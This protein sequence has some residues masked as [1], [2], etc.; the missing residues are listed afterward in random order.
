MPGRDWAAARNGAREADRTTRVLVVDDELDI[1]RFMKLYLQTEGYTVELALDGD[2]ALGA[3]LKDPPD[4]VVLD[5]ML[6][7]RDGL[8]VC[9]VLREDPRTAAIAIILV[10]AR[11]ETEDRVTGL[12]A[13][14]D[15]YI[16]KPFHPAELSARVGAALRRGRHLRSLSPLTGLPGNFE[17]LAE[18]ERLID[19]GDRPFA[20]VHADLDGFKAFNDHYGFL[21]GDEAIRTTG[22]V[23]LAAV[24]SVGG[25]PRFVGHI[26]GDDFAMVVA[27]DRVEELCE[28]VQAD[29]G[30]RVADLYDPEDREAGG[31]KVPDRQGNPHWFELLT[32]SMG[33]A[34]STGRPLTS[35]A[36]ASAIAS[37]LKGVAKKLP[38]TSWQ[39]DR[40][41]E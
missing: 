15:D 32:L 8:D 2:D 33:V 18:L 11:T 24:E 40:R 4:V 12:D 13:G 26:G 36:A 31:I 19:R 34:V 20:L 38:G 14:A 35:A 30:A 3:A 10:S 6:P 17:I 25:Q 37:E 21:R 41:R 39:V 7:G 5:V 29:F 23:I 16:S 9:K 28:R 1:A 22:S 27:A